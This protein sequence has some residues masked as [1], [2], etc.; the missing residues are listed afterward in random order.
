MEN[1]IKGAQLDLFADRLSTAAFRSNQLR[2]WLASAAYVL[3]HALRRIG[4]AN[5]ALARAWSEHDPPEADEDRRHR[6][7]DCAAYEACNEQCLSPPKGEFR[8]AR[9]R[10]I[11]LVIAGL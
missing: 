11:L 6:G 7:R 5:T 4:L 9:A 1:R 3:M 2:L 8:A 10:L